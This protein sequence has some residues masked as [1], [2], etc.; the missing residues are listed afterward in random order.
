MYNFNK[1]INNTNMNIDSNTIKKHVIIILPKFM[2][3]LVRI[4]FVLKFWLSKR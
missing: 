1:I 4:Y 3:D 2:K